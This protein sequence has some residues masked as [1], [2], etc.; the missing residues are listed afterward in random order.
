MKL[1][2]VRQLKQS[3]PQSL[4]RRFARGEGRRATASVAMGARS[5]AAFDGA[6]LRSGG[7][8]RKEEAR[9]P[10]GGPAPVA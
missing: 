8:G 6:E 7:R 10:A 4:D 5:I 3:I 2:S 1:E 9:L